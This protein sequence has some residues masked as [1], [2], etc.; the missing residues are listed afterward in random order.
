MVQVTL[1][2]PPEELPPGRLMAMQGASLVGFVGLNIGLNFF[3]SWA[4]KHHNGQFHFV[5][6][7]LVVDDIADG[8]NFNY[9][10]FYTMFH[11][12]ASTFGALIIMALKKPV[13]GFPSVRQLWAYK[14]Q[15]LPIATCTALSI[16]LN[17]LSLTLISLFLNQVIRATGPLPTM[18]FSSL[19][20][21]KRYSW[22]MALTCTA[23]V[24]GTILAIPFD[25]NGT[26]TSAAGL[27]IVI[28]S[29]LAAS[30]KPVV[31]SMVMQGSADQERLP[32]TVALFYDVSLAFWFMLIYWLAS[33][34]E[35]A[36]S[37]EYIGRHPDLAVGI[38]LG[39]ATMAFG[40]NLS[41]YYFIQFTSALTSTVVSN[42]VKVLNI[43]ISAAQAHLGD[44]RN[45]C[46]VALVCVSIA[47][48]AYLGH[49]EKKKGALLG[50]VA[51]SPAGLIAPFFKTKQVGGGLGAGKPT[52]VTPLTDGESS[53]TC[54]A[55]S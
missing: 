6:G 24:A 40:F 48:Y 34:T 43:V 50:A 8:P 41:S 33:P 30:F 23:I 55:I 5:G 37:I 14:L 35:R 32:P 31:V 2:A 12:L 53:A 51:G 29:T 49:L 54:C 21:G 3:N 20:E 27:I 16:G 26:T 19:I 52:E 11:M 42:G 18:V 36:Q 4:L 28:I 39:G 10:I 44:A 7:H 45:W 17:N 22:P 25:D 38:I 1:G 9:P 47:L 46:G 13:T 15:L